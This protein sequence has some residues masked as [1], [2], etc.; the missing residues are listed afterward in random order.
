MRT[1]FFGLVV[2]LTLSAHAQSVYQASPTDDVWYYD[3]AFNPGFTAILRVWGTEQH[4]V[5]PTGARPALNYSYS[6]ARWDV[7]AIRAGVRYQVL[8]AEIRVV[9]TAPPGYTLDEGIQFPLEA[10]TLT[11]SQFTEA[12]WNYN[13]PNNPYPTET[14]L[15]TGWMDFYT[16]SAPFVIP[17][18]LEP[19]VFEPYFNQAVNETGVLGV[20]FVARMD[21][22]AQGGTRIYRFYSRN[23]A[24]GRAPVLEVRYRVAGDVNSDGCV[25]DAD[26]L[27]ALFQ[28]GQ[29][30]TPS[31]DLNG[32]GTVDDADLLTVLFYFGNGC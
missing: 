18:R 3:N 31:A 28:F 17:I 25:D 30:G 16:L 6:L 9:Q 21:P 22:G 27:T 5:D 26:L 23:D 20:G 4:A 8:S 29:T 10:R 15:G 19:S 2:L 14:L 12:S 13:A 24:G 32:D 11:H 7:S 1:A